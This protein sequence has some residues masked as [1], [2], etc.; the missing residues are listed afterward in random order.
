[1]AAYVSKKISPIN[2]VYTGLE[3][4]YNTGSKDYILSQNFY[5]EKINKR[6]S[7][8]AVTFGHEFLIN[9]FSLVT[10]LGINIYNKFHQDRIKEEEITGLKE[11]IKTYVPARIGF[12]YYI[13]DATR[14]H[15]NNLYIG[16]YIKS[17]FGQADFLE[18]GLGYTF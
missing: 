10:T 5:E 4:Y 1:M 9:H 14:V 13:K 16:L 6:S 11:K 2:K 8:L 15:K 17:N 12:Q 18:S 7:V 3:Y